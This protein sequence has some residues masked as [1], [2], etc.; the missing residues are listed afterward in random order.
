LVESRAEIL[1]LPVAA[2]MIPL[3]AVYALT[4]NSLLFVDEAGNFASTYPKAMLTLP[5]R[6]QTLVIAPI[7]FGA[8]TASLLWIASAILICWPLGLRPP[9]LL[10]ALGSAP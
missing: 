5:V 8:L 7:T 10:P 9:L 6:S 3:F 1:G 4:L 2:S